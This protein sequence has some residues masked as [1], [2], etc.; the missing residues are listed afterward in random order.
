M[1]WIARCALVLASAGITFAA[2]SY[3]R[4]PAAPEKVA[5]AAPQASANTPKESPVH[6]QSGYDITPL[7]QPRI[8]ELAR[9]LTAEEAK[10]IL[11]KGTEPAFCGTLLDNKLEGT[12]ICRLCSLP[13]FASDSKFHSGTGWPSFYKPFDP[14]HV[15]E[16]SD[17]SYGMVRDEI[18][19]ARCGG[20]L[21]HVFDDAPQTPT[22]RRFCLNSAS[23][24]FVEKGTAFPP[25]AQPAIKTETAYFA[26]GCFWGIEDHLQQIPGVI[27]AVSGYMGGETE[28]PTYKQVC[29]EDT[30]HAETVRVIYNPAK[31]TYR[32]LLEWFFKIHDPTQVNR[33]G[34]DIGTQYRSAIFASTPEQAKEARDFIAA[35]QK[36][37]PRFSGRTIATQVVAPDAAGRFYEAEEYHQDYHVKHGG[38]CPLPTR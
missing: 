17:T 27:T 33:Q 13:L 14:A 28:N 24:E 30:G 10:I 3:A 34:P 35:Q 5:V 9:K 32:E 20:H 15:K 29:Y 19:C 25:A 21:G 2:L 18:L 23:L 11:N 36:S 7:A 26:G 38:S 1:N 31:V 22:G 12:Y 16:I 37:N 8:D 6:S 4:P